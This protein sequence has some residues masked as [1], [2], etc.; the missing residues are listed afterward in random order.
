MGG[1]HDL[2]YAA[3]VVDFLALTV[4]KVS[5]DTIEFKPQNAHLKIRAGSVR[6][7]TDSNVERRSLKMMNRQ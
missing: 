4:G 6:W 3:Q 2:V 1:V 5:P 7:A